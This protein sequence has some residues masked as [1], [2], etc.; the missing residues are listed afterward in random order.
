MYSAPLS[1]TATQRLGVLRESSD[2]FYIAQK[3]LEIRG[4]GELMG[5]KQTGIA[6]MRI[7]DLVRDGQLVP[8]V[9][10]IAE[11]LWQDYPSH[12]QAIINRWIGFKEQYGNA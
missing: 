6:E 5:T 10:N 2:G 1:K 7:A 12:A 9:Q 3:D 8:Q 4:P 11:R